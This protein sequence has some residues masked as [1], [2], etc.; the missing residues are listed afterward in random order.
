MANR[1]LRVIADARVRLAAWEPP[2][3]WERWDS[4]D[5]PATPGRLDL[6]DLPERV[7]TRAARDP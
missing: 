5:P 6:Q 3:E 2:A 7:V 4:L 1:V